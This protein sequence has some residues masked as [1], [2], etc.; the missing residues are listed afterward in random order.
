MSSQYGMLFAQRSHGA[1][2]G[3]LCLQDLDVVLLRSLQ[4]IILVSILPLMHDPYK[5]CDPVH[6]F[7]RFGELEQR[8]IDSRPFQRLRYIR[9]MGVAYLVYPGA[10]HTRFEHSL[11][12]MELVSRIFDAIGHDL[13][14]QK[15]GYWRQIL[16]LAALCHDMGHLPFSHT[17]EKVLLPDGGHEEMTMQMIRSEELRVIWQTLGEEAEEDI[18]KL[19]V[20]REPLTPQERL[21]AQVITEDN[22]GADRIDYLIRDAYYTGVGYGY[23]DHHQLIDSL[24]IL[25][26]SLGVAEGGIQS[27]EALWIARYMMYA[28]VY[29]HPKARVYTQHMIRFMQRYYDPSIP[30]LEQTDFVILTALMQAAKEGDYDALVLL[31]RKPAYEEVGGELPLSLADLGDKILVDQAP[32]KKGERRFAVLSEEGKVICSDQASPF[33]R[34]I[35]IGGKSVQVYTHPEF[36]QQLKAALECSE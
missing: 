36:T 8:V 12:V 13:P 35:P 3:G 30:Y 6:G 33:L 22:F 19:A 4:I 7:I 18:I 29:H 14:E 31:K 16:R 24:R 15:R 27:V 1:R 25:P 32:L 21:L 20:G 5:I 26:D 17:A 2:K 23:F 28:R 9:Q 11:G 34:E 10:T